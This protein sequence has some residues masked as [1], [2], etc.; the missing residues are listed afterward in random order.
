MFT[1]PRLL[2]AR[3]CKLTAIL[4]ALIGCGRSEGMARGAGKPRMVAAQPSRAPQGSGNQGQPRLVLPAVA[5]AEVAPFPLQQDERNYHEP[6]ETCQ[7]QAQVL[8]GGK[9][10]AGRKKVVVHRTATADDKTFQFPLKKSGW[11]DSVTGLR[12]LAEAL[13]KQSVGGKAPLATGEIMMKFQILRT[14]SS[15]PCSRLYLPQH[16]QQV[17]EYKDESECEYGFILHELQEK[18]KKTNG[19]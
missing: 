2:S 6:R 15:S 1:G 19:H 5:A 13:P 4:F 18:L 10:T 14:F 8:M 9:G 11:V 3:I 16:V 7:L 12:R 17:Q